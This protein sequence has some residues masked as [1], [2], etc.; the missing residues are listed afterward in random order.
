MSIHDANHP[1]WPFL[2]YTVGITGATVILYVNASDFDM[3]EG[4]SL[5]LIAILMGGWEAAERFLRSR[6]S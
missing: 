5:I 4:K 2:R 1:I 3:T 6:T